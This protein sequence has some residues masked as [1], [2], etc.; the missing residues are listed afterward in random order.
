MNELKCKLYIHNNEFT[1]ILGFSVNLILLIFDK[2]ALIL[3]K[4]DIRNHLAKLSHTEILGGKL[5]KPYRK[6]IRIEIL[7]KNEL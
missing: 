3:T 4:T 6:E 7:R 2:I 1:Y 5:L